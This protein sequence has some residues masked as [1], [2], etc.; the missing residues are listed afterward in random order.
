[1]CRALAALS[2]VAQFGIG[3]GAVSSCSSSSRAKYSGTE[4][5]VIERRGGGR[6]GVRMHISRE[7]KEGGPCP[8]PAKDD[9]PSLS[10]ISIEAQVPRSFQGGF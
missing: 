1:M 9:V 6:A 7:R 10:R 5:K 3:G 4:E 8:R 2:V